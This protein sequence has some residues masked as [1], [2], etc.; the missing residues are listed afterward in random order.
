MGKSHK[1]EQDQKKKKTVKFT[2]YFKK[3]DL[4]GR[5]K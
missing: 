3:Y 4:L 2:V 1:S 5:S